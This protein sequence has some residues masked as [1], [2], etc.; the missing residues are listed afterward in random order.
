M[1]WELWKDIDGKEL[2]II[3]HKRGDLARRR[4]SDNAKVIWCCDVDSPYEAQV[5]YMEYK[6]F[7]FIRLWW[8]LR[9]RKREPDKLKCTYKE[10]GWE[11]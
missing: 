6:G 1:K 5:K 10:I 9:Y 2:Y 3:S 11:E 8:W 7:K 4:L